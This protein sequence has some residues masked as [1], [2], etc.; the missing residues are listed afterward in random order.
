MILQKVRCTTKVLKDMA[1]KA[2]CQAVYGEGAQGESLWQPL[3]GA[4]PYSGF[5]SAPLARPTTFSGG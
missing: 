3:R 5:A 2:K 1:G 4:G